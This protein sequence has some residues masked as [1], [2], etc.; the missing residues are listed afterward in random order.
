MKTIH[1]IRH[2]K[3]SWENARLGDVQR[4]LAQR[5][6]KD[7][8][9][10]GQHI[11]AAGWNHRNIYCSQAKR[12]QMTIAG[13]AKSLP[14]LNIDWQIDSE[15]YTFSAG[16]LLDWLAELSDEYAEITLVGHNP[17]F[18]DLINRLCDARLDNLPTCGYAQLSGEL[19]SWLQVK[20]CQFK[21]NQLI[22]PKMFK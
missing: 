22:K 4:P 3:S 8:Q 19:D 11:M 10:M 9:I 18:T 21:L 5:G 15:L 1:L 16:V 2:A 13:L 12:A 20:K 17:A 14:D 7:C 6:I